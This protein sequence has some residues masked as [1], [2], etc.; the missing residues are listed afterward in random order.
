MGIDND[1]AMAAAPLFGNDNS[2]AAAIAVGGSFESAVGVA[3]G[4]IVVNPSDGVLVGCRNKLEKENRR[5]NS[6]FLLPC[7]SRS[8]NIVYQ[9]DIHLHTST[10]VACLAPTHIRAVLGIIASRKKSF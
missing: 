10:L 2:V 1:G 5:W 8:Y 4:L 7:Y 3:A 6:I 9:K